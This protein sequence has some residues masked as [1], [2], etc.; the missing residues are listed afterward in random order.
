MLKR[1]D[2]GRLPWAELLLD[3]YDDALALLSGDVA[4]TDTTTAA[5]RSPARQ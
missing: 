1:D 4:G 3:Q 5:A 2:P